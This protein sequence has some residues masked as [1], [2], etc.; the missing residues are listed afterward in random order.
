[1]TFTMILALLSTSCTCV[2]V[3]VPVERVETEKWLLLEINNVL[4]IGNEYNDVKVFVIF[5]MIL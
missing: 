5:T 1:M 2:L 3:H 4:L